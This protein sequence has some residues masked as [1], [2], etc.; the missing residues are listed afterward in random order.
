MSITNEDFVEKVRGI[1]EEW[2]EGAHDPVL[3]R[4]DDFMEEIAELL[5]QIPEVDD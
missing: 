4:A 1:I 2:E 5:E 3:I